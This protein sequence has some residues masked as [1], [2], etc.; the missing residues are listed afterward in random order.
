METAMHRL[1]LAL[2][3]LIPACTDDGRVDTSQ[4]AIDTD[5]SG[6]FDCADLDHVHACI[7][8]HIAD[9]C[10][11]ADINHDGVVDD[12]DVHDISVALHDSGHTCTAPM[13]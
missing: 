6:V 1:I 12:Q 11:L 13:H 4:Y 5:H 10:K 8:H 3:L 9:A 7:N 2:A